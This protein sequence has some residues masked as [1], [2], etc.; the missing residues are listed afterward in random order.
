MS[1]INLFATDLRDRIARGE[2]SAENVVRSCLE[3]IDATESELRAWA[4]LDRDAALN[5]A[6]RLDGYRASGHPLGPL[7]GVPV[8][9]KDSIDT[10]DMPTERGTVIDA[11]RRPSQDAVVVSRLRAAGAVILGKTACTELSYFTPVETRNPH[12]PR[13]TP[14]GSSSGSAAAVAAGHVPLA[15]GTQTADSVIRPASFC[16]IVGFKP[17]HGL[18]PRTGILMQAPPLD[19]VGAFGRTVEDAALLADV[20]AGYDPGDPDTRP[21]APPRLLEL[22][23]GRPPVRPD[24]AFVKGPVWDRAAPET[25]QGFAELVEAL[26]EACDTVDL[27]DAFGQAEAAHR[28]LMTTGF[29][30]NLRPY[31]ERHHDAVS[32]VVRRTIEE[33]RDV[34]AVDYLTALDWREV[35]N[36]GL[37]RIFERYDALIT[38]AA[39]GEAPLGLETTGNP[40][41]CVLWTFCGVPTVSLPL[42]Q[43]PNGLPVGVQLV[44][45][46]GH[47]GRLLRTARW[48]TDYLSKAD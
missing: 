47:D 3:R 40:A 26:S 15:V 44:G 17:S 9:I 6:K 21:I 10:A 18:V 37:E 27:P 42:L 22:A 39:I 5:H 12:D 24:L 25:Q 32:E 30:R 1:S 48:L 2:L 13:R 19:T 35:L 4:H 23:S 16:G 7:H 33:G 38:P 11:G 41:F 28:Q 36:D 29:A 43:G 31:Y 45:R 14:G 46:R 20:L 8:G 34:K